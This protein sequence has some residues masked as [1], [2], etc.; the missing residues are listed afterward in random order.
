[1][2][3]SLPPF[4]VRKTAQ[5]PLT[6]Q[7]SGRK[8]TLEAIIARETPVA[9]R[10]SLHLLILN[11]ERDTFRFPDSWIQVSRIEY[12]SDIFIVLAGIACE[13]LR[14]QP[15]QLMGKAPPQTLTGLR[16]ITCGRT[17]AHANLFTCTTCGEEGILDVHYDYDEIAAHASFRSASEKRFDIWRYRDLLPISPELPLPPLHI[18]WT[19][20]H[21]VPRLAQ[22]IG[23]SKLFL[24][25]DGR[26][27]TNSF[28][29]RA[30][31]V[32]VMKAMEFGFHTIACAST[33]NAASSLA[34]LSAAVG[35]K[36]YI[37]VPQRAPEPKVTQLLIFGATVLRVQGTYE[38]AF[39]LCK[40]A[41]ERFGWYNRNSGTNPYLVEGKKTAGLEI[42]EQ[43]GKEIPD[44]VVV[45][46]GDGCT[47]GGIGKGLQEM[48]RLG[49]IDRVPRLLGVQ[50]EGAK[51]MLEA[52]TSGKDLIP[53]DT[54][55][56][57][58]SIAVGTP[59][60]WRRAIQQ[61]RLSHGDM[62]AVSDEEILD[63]MR[64]TARLGGVFGEP[65]GVAGVAGLKK[66]IALGIVKAHESAVAAITGNGLKDI[67]SAKHA[68]GVAIDVGPSIE[69]L[70]K[71]LA[72]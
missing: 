64:M 46:V 15:G 16:C 26:N 28:K 36:S 14:Q 39:D 60:N 6:A 38:Q 41:C 25:D 72:T 10:S 24:K 35:L 69:G 18:G 29:D 21:D 5:H 54:N 43:F 65:A 68:A 11:P 55:T 13:V 23:I 45:S 33:G 1:L 56:I 22:A 59:R 8:P 27:P 20:V 66:A 44:W 71:A 49:V 19:P 53:T 3:F 51:P 34:G 37:F 40:Q 47:I 52:F 50:A 2:F 12:K 48:K 9:I 63:A 31:A 7:L 62:I 30:S 57:A 4:S 58:D 67:A 42:A 32:G 61:I 70:E 17:F